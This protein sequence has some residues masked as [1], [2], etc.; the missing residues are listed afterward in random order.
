MGFLLASLVAEFRKLEIRSTTMLN[1][2]SGI[3]V[4]MYVCVLPRVSYRSVCVFVCVA[5]LMKTGMASGR[6]TDW[7]NACYATTFLLVLV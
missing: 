5:F 4:C 3:R 6:T 1:Y 7:L 2:I